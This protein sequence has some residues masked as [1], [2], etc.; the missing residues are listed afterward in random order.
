MTALTASAAS[1]SRPDQSGP[2]KIVIERFP[3]RGAEERFRVWAEQF[4]AEASRAPGHEGGSVLSGRGG[5]GLILLRFASASALDAWQRSNAYESLMRGADTFSTAGDQSQIQS[6][7]ETWFT[8]PD[9]AAPMKPPPKWKMA[10]VTWSALLPIVIALAFILA[11]LPL[12]FLLNAAVSTAIPV[13]MLTWVIMP[14]AT[15]ALYG[16]LY[17]GEDM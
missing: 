9:R 3:R 1:T 11:P 17:R 4:V 7:L 15:R 13:V 5:H 8:L 12:P 10:L 6:G 2:A 16:W 14:R